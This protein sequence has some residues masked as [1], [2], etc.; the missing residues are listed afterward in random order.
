MEAYF[1][2]KINNALQTDYL[3]FAPLLHAQINRRPRVESDSPKLGY[4]GL[5]FPQVA[6]GSQCISEP[7]NA[8][9]ELEKRHGQRGGN[10]QQSGSR[11]NPEV[12]H[13]KPG[14]EARPRPG[15]H[16][17]GFVAAHTGRTTQNGLPQPWRFSLPLGHRPTR[18]VSL[19]LALRR[20]RSTSGRR[21]PAAGDRC[22]GN[23]RRLGDKAQAHGDLPALVDEHAEPM[24]T[25]AL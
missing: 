25:A 6:P 11:D 9:S 22:Y 24:V 23:R 18:Q 10:G 16:P 21:T 2:R 13:A 19:S 17:R 5:S 12:D 20:L 15:S 14:A 8:L 1:C 7:C 4:F 3:S